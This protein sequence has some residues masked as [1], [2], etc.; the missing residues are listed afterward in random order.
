MRKDTFTPPRPDEG[1]GRGE[2]KEAIYHASVSKVMVQIARNLRQNETTAEQIMWQ[3]LRGRR[4]NNLKFCRQHPVANTAFVSDFL[5]YQ[6]RLII[7]VDGQIHDN[8]RKEDEWR[9]SALEAQGHTVLRFTNKQIKQDL[10]AVLIK[11]VAVADKL[12]DENESPSP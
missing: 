4:L 10:D 12:I 9:Q 7:E 8:Q 1:E 2:Y 11:I 6:A 5:C 3:C